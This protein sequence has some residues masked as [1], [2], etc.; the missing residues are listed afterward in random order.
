[1][2]STATG[3]DDPAFVP[4]PSWPNSFWPQQRTAPA[5]RTAQAWP[6]PTAMPAALEM[7]VTATGTMLLSPDPF[8][9]EPEFAPQQRIVPS[10]TRAHVFAA[11]PSI[12]TSAGEGVSAAAFGAPAV[13][14]HEPASVSRD[15]SA[16][17][18]RAVPVKRGRWCVKDM[19][20]PRTH[21]EPTHRT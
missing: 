16:A 9:S 8:P 1:M 18:R 4:L 15:R 7:P 17:V 21:R 2:A 6:A 5:A 3:R 14:V 11:P 13:P 12:A 20:G 19:A 10:V